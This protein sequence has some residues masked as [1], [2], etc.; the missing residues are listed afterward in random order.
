MINQNLGKNVAKPLTNIQQFQAVL[1]KSPKFH[2]ILYQISASQ[3]LKWGMCTAE[4]RTKK[5]SYKNPF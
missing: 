3:L 4:T 5:A 2:F 1:F